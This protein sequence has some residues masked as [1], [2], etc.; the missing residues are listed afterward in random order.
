MSKPVRILAVDD[1]QEILELTQSLLESNGYVVL[2]A[3]TGG[4]ALRLARAHRPELVLLDVILPDLD[5]VQV[6]QQIKQD[7][8]LAGVFVI[9][10]SGHAIT[11]EHRVTGL[12]SGAD[13]YLTKPIQTDELLA[14]VNALTRIWRGVEALRESEARWQTLVSNAPDLILT[15]NGEGQ[16]EFANRPLPGSAGHQGIGT[17]WYD[18]FFPE[19][20]PVMRRLI[21]QVLETSV[22]GTCE[23]AG[24][25]PH[26]TSW[27][28]C[29]ISK[30]SHSAHAGRAIVIAT[31]I[32][33][34]KESEE[35]VRH[36]N[37]SLER[38]VVQRTVQ[39]EA[40]NRKLADEIFEHKQA[41]KAVRESEERFQMVVR[42]TNDAVWDWDLLT[43]EVWR[44]Q[45][46]RPLFGFEGKKVAPTI[47]FWRR[48]LHADDLSRVVKSLDVLFKRGGNSWSAEYRFRRG[49]GTYVP[50]YDRAYVVRNPKGKAVRLIGAMMDITERKRAE[51]AL[52]QLSRQIREAQET[53]RR[54]VARDLH[55]SVN[56]LLASVRFRLQAIE[57]RLIDFDKALWQDA[58]RTKEVLEHALQEVRRIS[59]NLRPSEL[60]D[61]GL[62]SAV[63]AGCH[64][65][66]E[67]TGLEVTFRCGAR[68]KRFP[69]EIELA[70]YRIFQE[71][72][73]N[74]E[75]HARA[76][77]VKVDLK[78]EETAVLLSIRDDGKGFRSR[79][80]S[81]RGTL[82]TGFG[83]VNMRERAAAI[84]GSVELHS[85][86]RRG[87]RIEVR[88]PLAGS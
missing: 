84:G 34:R 64:E 57:S 70:L 1:N 25:G 28:S 77:Q 65:L 72:L 14:R 82:R 86:P 38:R 74:V 13:E 35:R 24:L 40:A 33:E 43:D 46:F 55:D 50:V 87:T 67:R 11:S 76:H 53:E 88:A 5:G 44:N 56:Q 8:E 10:I 51:E 7:P 12:A 26:V 62:I 45:N 47:E 68:T 17:S 36:L 54:R 83:L 2:T 30:V 61:L 19:Y 23:A 60:D 31:D 21:G 39:L 73:T 32:T 4:D 22:P 75:K 29:R 79:R 78:K 48:R 18:Y 16:I 15:V 20:Q 69:P 59:R 9:L 63:R 41:E 27:F 3:A 81:G 52:R 42:A 49:D 37:E 6:C 71:A 85:L 58:V 80:A 66:Q